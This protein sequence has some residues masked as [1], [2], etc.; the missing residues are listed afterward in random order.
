MT[1]SP[2]A[3][4]PAPPAGSV[5]QNRNYRHFL[6]SRSCSSLA[7]QSLTVA[8]GW[9]IYEMTGS[10][11]MLGWI[12]LCQFLPMLILTFVVGTVADRYDRRRIGLACQWIEGLTV[13]VLAI[14]VWKG[15]LTP[16][17][18][19]IAVAV[20][21]AAQAFER[22][23][24]AALLPGIVG[25]AMLQRAI[26]TSTSFMQ[27]AFIVG[28]ALGGLLYGLHHIVPFVVSGLL[29]LIAGYSVGTIRQLEAAPPT[30]AP[31]TLQT[32]F[33]GVA[34]IRRTPA[35]LGMISLDLFAVLLG[36]ATAL[37]PIYASDILTAGPFGLGLLR[38][39]P[40]IGALG[41][42]LVLGRRP[43]LAGAG[44]KM[45]AAVAV[46]GLAT[47]VFALS[48][49]V[50]LSILAL[51][52]VGA[53]DNISVVIR[54]SLVQLMTPDDM[55][56]RVNAVNSLFIGTSNQLGEFESGMMAGFLGPVAAGVIG[57]V[58]TLAVVAIWMS[59][60]P[61]LRRIERLDGR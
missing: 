49:Q 48:T 61:V 45:F 41:M 57:G 50:W 32:V 6:I 44:R 38:A 35:V 29:C 56:G 30:R 23:T 24:L 53:S 46:F 7:F 2:S 60:F 11:W 59:A 15:L 58:G 10:A 9:M 20:L 8:M 14:L 54:S 18:I 22:P 4:T 28:P 51:L 26:A 52:V 5:L 36:G 37:L 39:A 13:L 3:L 27:T 19:L 55:R 34:F 25:P 42:S 43:I 31:V 40:A 21:G 12:G 17:G 1:T 16:A 33:A 47:I